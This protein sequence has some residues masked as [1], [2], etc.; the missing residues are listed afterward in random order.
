VRRRGGGN[1]YV[2]GNPATGKT[3]TVDAVSADVKRR[4]IV[5]SV[6]AMG[7]SSDQLFCAIYNRIAPASTTTKVVD[8]EIRLTRVTKSQLP[9]VLV[10]DEID[11]LD[12]STLERLLFWPCMAKSRVTL[13]SISND[14]T[15]L[16]RLAVCK[17]RP[18]LLPQQKLVFEP[19]TDA[20]LLR[21]L[22]D[23]GRKDFEPLA[24]T[25]CAKRSASAIKGDIRGC[26]AFAAGAL[27]K[28]RSATD[29]GER[30]PAKRSK[31]AP[32]AVVDLKEM[33]EATQGAFGPNHTAIILSLPAVQQFLLCIITAILQEKNQKAAKT[34]A[35]SRKLGEV[36]VPMVSPISSRAVAPHFFL[37]W[38]D[39]FVGFVKVGK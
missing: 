18:Q 37:V 8:L 35:P 6:N 26:L 15:F 25:L 13:I 5:V 39:R 4:A 23:V 7:F 21:I 33:A 27:E 24:L 17:R 3:Y 31:V 29:D 30:P 2:C 11:R 22:E 34:A 1:L 20:Q 16:E 19:Y 32:P 28:K 12:E 10:I 38:G 9:V 14:V 36:T